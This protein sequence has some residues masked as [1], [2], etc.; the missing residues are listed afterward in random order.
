LDYLSTSR[1]LTPKLKAEPAPAT[2][3][4]GYPLILS[5]NCPEHLNVTTFLGRSIISSPVAGFLPLL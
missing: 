2:D 3:T 1:Q 5:R 4:I